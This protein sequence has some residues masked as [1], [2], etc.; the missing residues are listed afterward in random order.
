MNTHYWSIYILLNCFIRVNDFFYSEADELC[1]VSQQKQNF[2]EKNDKKD[3]RLLRFSNCYPPRRHI[4]K[5][6]K[7]TDK[8]IFELFTY[9]PYRQKEANQCK[10]PPSLVDLDGIIIQCCSEEQSLC[11][12]LNYDHK[13]ELLNDWYLL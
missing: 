4:W 10:L 1:L 9:L 8:K 6:Q 13:S 2:N 5:L 12:Y 7:Y 3:D 11:L